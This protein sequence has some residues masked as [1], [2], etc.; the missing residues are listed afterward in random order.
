MLT[1]QLLHF[2]W[3]AGYYNKAELATLDGQPVE[4][5]HSGR[6]NRNS[7]PDFLQARIKIGSTLFAGAVEMHLRTSHWRQH[8]HSADAAYNNVVLHVVWAHDGFDLPHVPVLELQPRV[9]ASLLHYYRQLME[10]NLFIPCAH[11]VHAVPPLVW[12]SWKERLLTERL[13]QKTTHI[14]Q[15]LAATQNDWEQVC[16]QLVA[17]YAGGT[18]NKEAFEEIAGMVLGADAADRIIINAIIPLLFAYAQATSNEAQK[19]KVLQWLQAITAEQNSIVEGFK[20]L[21]VSATT[22]FDT[23]ALLQLK[24]AYCDVR[25]C[26]ECAVGYRLLKQAQV[27]DPQ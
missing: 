14:Q 11:L 20:R 13:V 6:Y 9:A 27:Q 18:V 26:L 23:Q 10:S 15:L 1:E 16:W 5:M 7:G 12:E 19:E 4:I 22:A 8:K 25:R 17:R 2:I 3:Q 21:G 24:P